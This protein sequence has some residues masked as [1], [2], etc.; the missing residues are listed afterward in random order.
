MVVGKDMAMHDVGWAWT[1]PSNALEAFGGVCAQC[2][3]SACY[4]S[5]LIRGGGGGVQSGT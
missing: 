2:G 5:D 1:G 4:G 3:H